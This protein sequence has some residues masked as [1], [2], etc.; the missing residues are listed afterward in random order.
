MT[1]VR[2]HLARVA[3]T[4]GLSTAMMVIVVGC[5]SSGGA[6]SAPAKTPTAG[7][8]VTY[9]PEPTVSAKMICSPDGQAALST[10]LNVTAKRVT[11]PTWVDHLYSCTYQYDSGSFS[12][13]VKELPTIPATI[14]YYNALKAKSTVAQPVALGQAGFMTTDNTSIVRKDNKVLDIDVTKLPA[15]FGQPPRSRTDV[16]LTIAVALLGCWTGD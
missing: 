3:T 13:S 5:S 1:P 11:T 15:Q 16:S 6:Q 14:D 2:G 7:L 8:L 4:L 10:A 12:V 9:G